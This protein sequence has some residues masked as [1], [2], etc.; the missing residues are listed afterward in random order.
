MKKG[1]WAESCS[2]ADCRIVC[3]T[4][5]SDGT[6]SIASECG[7]SV[8]EKKFDVW[9][10]DEARNWSLRCIPDD[11]DIFISLDT[12]EIL[13]QGWREALE[14]IKG[15]VIRP[16]YKHVWP[17]NKD[18]SDGLVY[19][20]DK[21]HTTNGHKWVHPVHEVLV[22]EIHEVQDQVQALEIKE[23]PLDYLCEADARG[24]KP[25]DLIEISSYW[26][27][28]CADTYNME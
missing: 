16:R 23:K 24:F 11:V 26:V 25:H 18:G 17:W 22:P 4:G 6:V 13:R 9:R 28:L 14:G 5:S 1:L 7:V 10:F 19:G 27:G 2:N 15:N 12:D 20:G 3:D 8:Y 21:I